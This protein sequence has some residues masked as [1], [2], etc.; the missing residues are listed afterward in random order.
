VLGLTAGVTTLSA[1]V[2]KCA[3]NAYGTAV[4]WGPNEKGELGNGVATGGFAFPGVDNNPT[5]V[6]HLT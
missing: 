6:L 3:I 5:V 4:C 2:A 1:N